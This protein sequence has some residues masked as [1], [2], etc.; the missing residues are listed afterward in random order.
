MYQL[1]HASGIVTASMAAGIE[2]FQFRFVHASALAV[3]YYVDFAAGV[4]VAAAAATNISIV[5]T[6]ARAWTVAGSGGARILLTGNNG[7]LRTSMATSSVND[8][9]GLTTAAAG[10]TVGTKTLDTTNIGSI[11]IPLGTGAITVDQTLD[12]VP[13]RTILF[14]GR[15]NNHPLVLVNQEG[16][17][18]RNGAVAFPATLTWQFAVNVHWAE[19]TAF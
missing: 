15:G 2:I 10:L 5:M 14:D 17:V 18:I 8:A 11:L 3:V 19:V 7:K 9:G 4:T 6:P 16:F 1:S 12:L 13:A